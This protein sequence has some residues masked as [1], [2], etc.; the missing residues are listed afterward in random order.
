MRSGGQG[1]L[2]RVLVAVLGALVN[3]GCYD[4]NQDV[5]VCRD[6]G[7]CADPPDPP[8]NVVATAGS[9]QATI[10]W[11]PPANNGG[12]AIT[13]YR[14]R[15]IPGSFGREVDASAT[16]ATVVGLFSGLSYTFGVSARNEVGDS[17]LA[18]SNAVVPY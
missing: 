13:G 4:F 18:S 7:R 9:S 12:S 16:T 8:L 14:V 10:S 2:L 5:Q 3:A 11:T 15:S 6:A 1:H 17:L